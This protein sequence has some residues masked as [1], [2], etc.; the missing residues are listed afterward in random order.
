M[1]VA[2]E[3][4]KKIINTYRPLMANVIT[5]YP[6]PLEAELPLTRNLKYIVE[7]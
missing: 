4:Y 5:E 1:D 6:I 2:E 7:K 3:K